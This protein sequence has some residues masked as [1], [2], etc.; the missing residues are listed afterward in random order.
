MKDATIN[1]LKKEL[2]EIQKRV[3]YQERYTSKDC[4]IFKNFPV[5]ATHLNIFAEMCRTISYFFKINLRH[6]ALKLVIHY[7]QKI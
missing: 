1:Q 3:I 2:S 7:R 5:P 6:K 4:L